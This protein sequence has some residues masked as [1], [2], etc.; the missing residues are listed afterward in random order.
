MKLWT[1]KRIYA[2]LGIKPRRLTEYRLKGLITPQVDSEGKDAYLF[3][4]IEAIRAALIHLGESQGLTL[5]YAVKMSQLVLNVNRVFDAFPYN[6]Q[7]KD[8]WL[9][10]VAG[11]PVDISVSFPVDSLKHLLEVTTKD[12]ADELSQNETRFV[13]F[14]KYEIITNKK[15]FTGYEGGRDS[16]SFLKISD[17][18]KSVI[19]LLSIDVI[20]DIFYLLGFKRALFESIMKCSELIQKEIIFFLSAGLSKGFSWETVKKEI[21]R[22]GVDTSV[23]T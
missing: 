13:L 23:L 10:S 8:M 19:E 14:D 21:Q 1:P 5:E 15:F 7:Y 3:N 20:D 2:P 18:I 17:Y 16:V 4:G 6:N 11:N 12:A 9:I 22:R